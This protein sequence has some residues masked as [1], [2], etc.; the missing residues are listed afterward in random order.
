MFS[1]FGGGVLNLEFGV[2]C[3]GLVPVLQ[4]LVMTEKQTYDLVCINVREAF[5]SPPLTIE[6]TTARIPVTVKQQIQ[7]QYSP[8]N[9]YNTT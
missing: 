3:L 6:L 1:Y 7:I 2:I 9:L 4:A 8:S 5:P